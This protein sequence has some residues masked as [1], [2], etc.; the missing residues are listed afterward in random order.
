MPMNSEK[1]QCSVHGLFLALLNLQGPSWGLKLCRLLGQSCKQIGLYLLKC[2][3][4]VSRCA[5]LVNSNLS[6]FV[7]FFEVQTAMCH[8]PKQRASSDFGSPLWTGTTEDAR[9]RVRACD[10]HVGEK[11]VGLHKLW[12]AFSRGSSTAIQVPAYF[13]IWKGVYNI[14]WNKKEQATKPCVTQTHFAF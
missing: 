4:H 2:L 10:R 6:V 3:W 9:I 12:G 13:S 7:F 11:I 5:F 8:L 1:S 14:F